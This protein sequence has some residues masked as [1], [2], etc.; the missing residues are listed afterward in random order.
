[1]QPGGM[2]N[3]LNDACLAEPQVLYFKLIPGT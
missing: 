3:A 1:M 2:K